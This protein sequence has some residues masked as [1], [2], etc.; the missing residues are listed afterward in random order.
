MA[1]LEQDEKTGKLKWIRDEED[2]PG[3]IKNI[4]SSSNDAWRAI[5]DW[6]NSSVS[7]EQKEQWWIKGSLY[8]AADSI[9]NVA[10][11]IIWETI[12][13]F[14]N[15]PKFFTD[16]IDSAYYDN[17]NWWWSDLKKEVNKKQDEWA[18]WL[19]AWTNTV[20]ENSNTEWADNQSLAWETINQAINW[21][22]LR[23]VWKWIKRWSKWIRWLW[24]WLTKLT[25]HWDDVVKVTPKFWKYLRCI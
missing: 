20:A 11:S 2:T 1:H 18:S 19:S 25:T 9:N 6:F 8:R 4:A 5:E 7:K 10:W 16:A 22:L 15:A 17:V 12:S 21:P 13:A 14:W 24:N 23:P 3:W